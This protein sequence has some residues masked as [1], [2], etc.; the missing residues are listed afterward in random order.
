MSCIT[1]FLKN[2]RKNKLL[3]QI[4]DLNKNLVEYKSK[5]QSANTSAGE[6]LSFIQ[7][8]QNLAKHGDTAASCWLK[9]Y[10]NGYLSEYNKYSDTAAVSLANAQNVTKQIELLEQQFNKL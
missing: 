10:L 8:Q 1:I 9:T 3:K 2:R 4:S 5:S 7:L 6:I